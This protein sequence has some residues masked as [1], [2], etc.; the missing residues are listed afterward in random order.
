M[1]FKSDHKSLPL[2]EMLELHQTPQL[3]QLVE[4]DQAFDRCRIN[5]KNTDVIFLDETSM[6]ITLCLKKKALNCKMFALSINQYEIIRNNNFVFQ[7][8][9]LLMNTRLLWHTKPIMFIFIC[10]PYPSI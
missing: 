5:I 4:H 1:A 9:Y 7:H 6:V 2:L 3:C 10:M 8:M